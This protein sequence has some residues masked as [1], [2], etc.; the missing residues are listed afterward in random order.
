MSSLDMKLLLLSV[1]AV[2]M[3]G[4]MVPSAFAATT[5]FDE[6][7]EKIVLEKNIDVNIILI[8]DSWLASQVTSV[9]RQLVESYEP[10]Y[11]LTNKKVGIKYNFEY[12]FLEVTEEDSE[13]L[14][15]KISEKTVVQNINGPIAWWLNEYQG[16][17]FNSQDELEKNELVI[18]YDAEY[19]ENQI[20]E[21]IIKDDSKL[22]PNDKV[23]LIFLKDKKRYENLLNAETLEEQK[24]HT[25]YQNYFIQQKNISGETFSKIGLTG[26]GGN[27][28]FYF[29]DLYAMPWLEILW[30][31]DDY[32]WF[33]TP[34]GME[35]LHDCTA[36]SC[37]SKIIAEDVNSAIH[38]IVTP[39]FVYPV[40][41]HSNY[42][43]DVVV[44]N[45][46]T[47][48]SMGITRSTIDFFINEDKVISEVKELYPFANFDIE[49]TTETRES[50]GISLE[51]K[52]AIKSMQHESFVTPFGESYN[53]SVLNSDKIKPHLLSWAEDRIIAKNIPNTKTIPVLVVMHDTNLDLYI[54]NL[55]VTGFAAGMPDD[56][57][58]SCCSFAIIDEKDVWDNK[59]DSTDLVIHEVG[60]TLGLAHSFQTAIGEYYDFVQNDYWNNYASPM[61]YGGIPNGCGWL[62]HYLHPDENCGIANASFT[63]FETNAVTDMAVASLIRKTNENI[64]D[65]YEKDNSKLD[66][67][68]IN[69]IQTTIS[70]AKFYF[71]SG[72]I[73]QKNMAVEK[74]KNAYLESLKLSDNEIVDTGP[75]ET[76]SEFGSVNVSKQ[77]IVYEKYN[78]MSI[79]ISG[80]IPE[81]SFSKGQKITISIEGL[82]L[83]EPII[84]GYPAS[85]LTGMDYSTYYEEHKVRP[86]SNGDFNLQLIM[87]KNSGIG[88][89]QIKVETIDE[90]IGLAKF[91][92][93]NQ[94]IQSKIPAWIKNNAGWWAEGQIDDNSF[95]QGIQFMIKENI[96]SIPNLLESSSETADSVP[97]WIKNNA[98]WWAEG[99]IDDNSFVQG[100]EYLVKVGII[101]V[102]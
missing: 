27:Y 69:T 88:K 6:A 14:F 9:E 33:N 7:E 1:L 66:V 50:R 65:V 5:I 74:A 12:K 29:F 17:P 25:M 38:H 89:Y 79:E 21:I 46:P 82:E 78:Q 53:Y 32:G 31:W 101:Q 91:E 44:Y 37:F 34:I 8:G 18:Q 100:I 96:I 80:K 90:I 73:A 94:P 59:I 43:L 58:I 19:V 55:G 3:I 64:V 16:I 24:K 13:K 41:Y 85:L 95:V 75:I 84:D 23:N 81:E 70:D 97:T 102:N 4:L 48:S 68:K 71:N 26:Y 2:T 72:Q 99:Q 63:T 54:D 11:L 28:N 98:G 47:G 62:F 61:T 83:S 35:N 60:H 36:A 67:S 10:I 22:S 56:A 40:D 57:T 49:I 86:T 87:P 39:S 93:I 30:L 20:N 51:F 76:E 52:N 15:K 45:L 77:S 92:I 42:L